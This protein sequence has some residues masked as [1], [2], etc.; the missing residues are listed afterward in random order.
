MDGNCGQSQE[1]GKIC[2]GL[3]H[4]GEGK[5]DIVPERAAVAIVQIADQEGIAV[6]RRDDA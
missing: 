3:R 1:C 2:G 6:V 4:G 5:R